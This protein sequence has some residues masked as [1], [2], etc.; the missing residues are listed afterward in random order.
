MPEITNKLKLQKPFGSETVS[1]AKYNEN[2]RLI[3]L[4][5]AAQTQVDEPFYLKHVEY[6]ATTPSIDITF[7]PGRVRF[8]D[9][10]INKTEDSTYS[11]TFPAA[12][13]DYVIYI[14]SDGTY[15]Y[16]NGGVIVD[17]AVK[18]WKISTGNSVAQITFEDKRGQLTG[19]G[20]I[21]AY[22]V[23]T[24]INDRVITEIFES[25]GTTVKNATNVTTN[26]NG[27]PI[28]NILASDGVTALSAKNGVP[29]GAV[30]YFAAANAPNGYLK[31]N[32]V[33]VSRTTYAAL[34]EVIG[35]TYGVGDGATTFNLPDLRGEFIRGFDNGRGIDS[36]RTFGSYQADAFQGHGH[37]LYTGR[38][39][40]TQ[41][42][43]P[44]SQIGHVGYTGSY[45][46]NDKVKEAIS[47]GT[48]GTPR[49]ASESRPRNIALL[50]CIKY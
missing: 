36:G 27:H 21:E 48:H 49:I 9:V 44:G 31:C 25:N 24:K 15:M 32:G 40:N 18:I 3:D 17:R 10:L 7:G 2:L 11:I 12:N 29:V 46:Y 4:N 28:S 23:T 38:N 6:N 33:A 34:Y 8:L 45:L 22:N 47:D 37:N 30:F 5:A 16:T 1:L 13:T 43:G 50:P 20:A 35:L 42:H 19:A 26:I 39:D 41:Y 14:K